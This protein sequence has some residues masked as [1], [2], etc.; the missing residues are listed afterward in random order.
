M[1]IDHIK[2]GFNPIKNMGIDPSK[3]WVLNPINGYRPQKNMGIEPNKWVST[4]E[5][6][7]YQPQ[8]I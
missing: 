4:P 2:M 8:K 5:K 7:G 6:Y 1:G 3:I